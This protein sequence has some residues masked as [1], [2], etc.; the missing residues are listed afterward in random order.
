MSEAPDR[1]E[2]AL[3]HL[4]RLA[5]QRARL[6]LTIFLVSIVPLGLY[7]RGLTVR[8]SFLDLLPRSEPP[9]AQLEDV[10]EHARSTSDVAVGISTEDRA[11]A[12]R[13]GRALVEELERDPEIAGIGGFVDREALLRRRLLFVPE[14]ELRTLVDRARTSIDLEIERHSPFYLGLD[15]DDGA[16]G[17]TPDE[18]LS[19]MEE[20]ERRFGDSDWIVTRDGDYLVV[21]AYFS[22]NTGDLAFGREAWA[23]V[24]T[25]VDRLR[26]GERFPRDLNVR[27]AGGIPSRV[28]DERVLVADLGIAGA[29][30]F[31]AVVLLIV[32]SLR[33]PRALL[34]L[35]LPLFTGLVWTFAFARLAV[36]H[37]NIISGFLFSILS[38]LGIEYGIH[39]LHR[40]KEL[41]AEGLALEPA[42]EKLVATTGR[43][44]FSGSMTNAGVFAVIA[45]ADFEGFSEFGLIASV[46]LIL[47]LVATLL[48]LPALLVLLERWRPEKH[49]VDADHDVPLRIPRWVRL[50][51]LVVLPVVA[52]ISISLLA[53]GTIRFDGN[54]RHLVSD[55][56][57]TRFGEYLRHQLAGTYDQALLWV[58]DDAS[59]PR[60]TAAVDAVRAER[61]ARGEPFDIIDVISLD[62]AF[63]SPEA[64]ARRLAII[65][66]LGTELDRIRPEYLDEAGLLRLEEGRELVRGAIPFSI[67]EMP[68]SVVGHF[69]TRDGRGSIVHLSALE[70]DDANTDLLV[71]WAGQAEEISAHLEEA[72]VTAPMLSENWIAGEIFE[73]IQ[74]DAGFLSFATLAAVLLVL[75]LDL[76]R[77]LISL[78][79]LGS[80]LIGVVSMAL[81]AHLFG[82]RL[83]FMNVAILP[84]CV[85]ISLDNAIHVFHRH[86][87]GG[88]GSIEKVLRQTTR[89]N[90]LASA[91]NLLGF[92]ALVITHHEGLR[93]VAWIATIGVLS[94][95][96]STTLWFPM[97]LDT[98]D[99]VKKPTN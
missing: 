70:R 75:V 62:D 76:R 41:R 10:L 11:L 95:Y 53:T 85:S 60:V 7:A 5:H 83:N 92:L 96:A 25:I 99:R 46:G 47:T 77:P 6:F 21:W 48:G 22:G 20:S 65:A 8:S 91:T 74:H 71:S 18:L 80:V 54:W 12:E 40:Y 29:I 3:G 68:Y 90:A 81:F 63:P 38:G 51:T 66:E 14:D 78:G 64:Q 2:R 34:L 72:G 50:G 45:L 1:L 89:A 88:P 49:V 33:T 24:Q 42:I 26:D 23:R 86:K 79:V 37:L 32:L 82:V 19:E 13:F 67:D 84:V 36:G 16:P 57:T 44:L 69:L 61:E 43:A 17:E 52:A 15:E 87:E 55:T 59:L 4:G 56:E 35:A 39:L 30:G 93:S 27:Y 97:V 31:F 94:T 73:R 58:E 9:V 28:E 98:L